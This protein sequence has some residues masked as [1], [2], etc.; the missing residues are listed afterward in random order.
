MNV[1]DCI[2]KLFQMTTDNYIFVYTPPKVGSTSLVTSLRVSLNRSYNIIHIHDEI[3]LSVLTGIHNVRINDI[4]T[5][6]S[7][8]GRNVFVIDVYRTPVERKMSEYFEKLSPY[9]FNNTESNISSYNIQRLFDRF[10]CLF[11]N[12]EKGDHYFEQYGIPESDIVPFD[13]HNKYTLQT[14]NR[15]K[16]IKLRLC[17]SVLWPSI[18]SSIFQTDI[19]LISDYKTEDKGVG[20]LYNTFKLQYR[21]P[22][23]F[24]SLLQDDKYFLFYYSNE[25]RNNYLS[26]WRSKLDPMPF[27]PYSAV[28]YAF[29]IK[30]CLENQ[31]I[32]DVQYEHYIDNGCFCPPCTK[33]RREIYFEAKKGEKRFDKIVHHE[34][35]NE[36]RNEKISIVTTKIKQIL[37]KSMT[38]KKFTHNQFSINLSHK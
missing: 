4:L 36:A 14:V 11:P 10:N 26:F 37:R 22:A 3:M 8:Q 23:N 18:L 1:S 32:N 15:V 38:E 17:D 28:E 16:Y 31:H 29:Y 13:F 9:H 25:E 2:N 27:T 34:Q 19:V 30:L 20:A 35:V 7:N 33:R 24:L 6:L 12:L 21:L 5:F